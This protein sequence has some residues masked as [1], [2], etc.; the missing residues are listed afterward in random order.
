MAVLSLPIM[1]SLVAEPLTGLVDTA[2][3][4][5]LGAVPLAALGVGTM[6]MSSFF[7]IFNF[8]GIGTQTEIASSVGQGQTERAREVAGLAVILA[9]ALG[10][11]VGLAFLPAAPLIAQLLG[12]EG[13][14]QDT[15]VTYL[16]WRLLSTPAVLIMV[17]SFGALR[18]LQDM[19][20]PLWIATGLNL[21]NIALDPLLIFGAGPIPA[22]GVAGA[23]LATAISHWVGGLLALGAVHRRLGLPHHVRLGDAVRLLVVGRDLFLR[24]ALLTIFLLLTTRAATRIGTNAG[25]AH[26]AVRQVWMLTALIL[27]AFATA[28]QSL[29]GFF[30]G[31]GQRAVARRVAAVTCQWSLASGVA[32]TLLM[33][34]TGRLTAAALVPVEAQALFYPA[35][36]VAALSM[37]LNSLSFAVDGIHWG[38]GDYRFLRN[39]MLLS[40]A[41]GSLGI[42]LLDE[43][44]AGA[45]TGVWLITVL[46]ITLRAVFGMLRIW[47]GIGNSPFRPPV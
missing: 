35:W 8:L 37:P 36:T 19:R 39:V 42:W 11:V 41:A 20:T 12:A 24:T 45:L 3:V 2:F 30:I 25:A 4:A 9:A 27:D 33:L 32:L 38:S 31:A 40:T 22:M 7:W 47:P 21:L 46:W 10:V 5:R 16:R 18:G 6:A 34:A 17:A 29:V 1:L 23:A 13:A 26:Q 15:A 28:A 43:S 14:L 44:A